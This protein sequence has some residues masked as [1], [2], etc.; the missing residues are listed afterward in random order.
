MK[1][2]LLV[3]LAACLLACFSYVASS[4]ASSGWGNPSD[5]FAAAPAPAEEPPV[6]GSDGF[7]C[8]D[9][10]PYVPGPETGPNPGI[11]T[12]C[13]DLDGATV[14]GDSGDGETGVC[15]RWCVV[16]DQPNDP[17]PAAESPAPPPV[18]C[19]EDSPGDVICG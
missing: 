5:P 8:G 4:Q 3:S 11:W 7:T 17:T 12:P 6:G 13:P 9:D 1:R 10:C 15:Q 18:T 16:Y 19:W 14:C 2:L